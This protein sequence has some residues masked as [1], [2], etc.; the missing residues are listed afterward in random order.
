MMQDGATDCSLSK[1]LCRTFF[2]ILEF[3]VGGAVALYGTWRRQR[4]VKRAG[5]LV[6]LRQQEFQTY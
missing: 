5:A 6:E 3:L 4:W 1:V 2:V